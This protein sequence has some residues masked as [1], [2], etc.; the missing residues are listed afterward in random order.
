M[1]ILLLNTPEGLKP[2]YDRD[3]DEKKKLVLGKMYK[4]KITEPRNVGF[5]NK[6]FKMIDLAWEYQNEKVCEHFKNDVKRFR[7]TVEVAAGHCDTVFNLRTKEWVDFPKSISFEEMDE[8][9]F[10]ELYDKV[11]NVLFTVF[12]RDIK[13]EEFE[14]FLNF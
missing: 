1:E 11:K 14:R 3:Y 13:V 12:L 5:N 6:Y 9:Q 2:C 8:F 4:A 10:R 7:K